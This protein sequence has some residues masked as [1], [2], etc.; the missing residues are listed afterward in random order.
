MDPQQALHSLYFGRVDAETDNRL[1]TCFVGTEMLRQALLP[2]HSLFVGAKGSGK[3]ALFRSLCGDLSMWRPLLPKNY[4]IIFRIPATGLQSDR[5]LSG[6]DLHELSPQTANDFRAF[7]LLYIGLK[8]ATTF[9]EDKRMQELVSMSTNTQ[10]RAHYE[11]LERIVKVLG[12]VG[13]T[14][15]VEKIRQR[16]DDLVGERLAEY[17]T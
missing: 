8:T 3:S 15:T 17:R 7:W 16:I 9:V 1:N 10:V 4:E 12:L 14:N 6:V 11:T 5:Y 13:T 2:Q